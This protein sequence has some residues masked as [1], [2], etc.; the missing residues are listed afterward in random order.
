[1]SRQYST[2]E[3][4]SALENDPGFQKL[5][6]QQQNDLRFSIVQEEYGPTFDRGQFN[7]LLNRL[8]GS[9]I[10]QNRD[11][12]AQE[13]QNIYSRGLSSMFGNF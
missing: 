6:K 13:R 10:R 5:S 3:R 4:L 1:M 9:K 2:D 7:F 12:Q 8:T 11:A